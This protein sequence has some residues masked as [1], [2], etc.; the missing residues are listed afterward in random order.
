MGPS[1]I[2]RILPHPSLSRVAVA[3]VE[4]RFLL[5]LVI[6][7][8]QFW[9][10]KTRFLRIRVP[11]PNKSSFIGLLVVF[12]PGKLIIL[13]ERRFKVMARPQSTLDRDIFKT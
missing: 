9:P 12:G 11:F 1:H 5:L 10:L 6:R 2:G 13:A 7:V 3:V 8:C 4:V